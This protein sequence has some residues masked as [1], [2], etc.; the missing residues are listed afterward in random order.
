[1]VVV[2]AV[3]AGLD[4]SVE[5]LAD[6]FDDDEHAPKATTQLTIAASLFTTEA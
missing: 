4:G 6:G 1:V 2:T 3:L 5:G